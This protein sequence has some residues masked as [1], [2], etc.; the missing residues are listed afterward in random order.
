SKGDALSKTISIIQIS[1]FIAQCIA[2][3][4][5]RLPITLLE[6]TA[7]AFAGISITTYCLWWYKP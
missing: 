6:M 1:G 3:V 7:L 4:T 2:R 5:Q